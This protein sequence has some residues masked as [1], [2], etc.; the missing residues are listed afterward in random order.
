MKRIEEINERKMKKKK[1]NEE[2]SKHY[3]KV[4]AMGCLAAVHKQKTSASM[5]KTSNGTT[6]Y[7]V[8]PSCTQFI[9]K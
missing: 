5:N 3:V 1:Q 7:D 9:D 4:E 6:L 2:V 8:Q